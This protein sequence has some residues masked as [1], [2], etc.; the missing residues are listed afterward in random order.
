MPK[1]VGHVGLGHLSLVSAVCWSPWVLLSVAGATER[2]GR[3][4]HLRAFLLAGILTGVVFLADPR[5]VPPLFIAA[6]GYGAW[7][8]SLRADRPERPA[9]AFLTGLA[10]AGLAL[11]AVGAALALPL[12]EF[13][14]LSTRAELTA[15]SADTLAL[16]AARLLGLLI[17][18]PGT[19]AEWL[20]SMGSVA[21]VLAAAGC[22]GT[23]R[24]VLYWAALAVAALLLALGQATPL[25]KLVSMVPGF[26]MT[27]VPARWLFLA[28]MGLA[29]LAAYGLAA[30]EG[31]IEAAAARRIR[32]AALFAAA[33]VVGISL[34]VSL[35]SDVNVWGS[36]L[37]AVLSAA[38]IWL[39]S[40]G[41]VASWAGVALAGL[42]VAEL[43][44]IDVT[45]VEARPEEEALSPGQT[46]AS[47]LAER[48][49][50]R[51]FSPSYAV[52]QEAAAAAGLELADGVHPLQLSSYVAYMSEAAG[53]DAGDYSVTLPPFP[54][55]DPSDDWGP[56]L[57][58]EAL[59]L[60]GIGRIASTYPVEAPGLV[61][62]GAVGGV[63]LYRNEA[64][65][66][67][68]WVEPAGGS[69][70][71]R[72]VGSLSRTANRV[73]IAAEGPGRLVLSDPMY[74]GWTATVDETGTRIEVYRGVT[75]SISLA[76]GAHTIVFTFVP[77]SLLVGM[78]IAVVAAAVSVV[79]WR[80]P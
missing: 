32:L 46:V 77:V 41:R 80:R 79:L 3:P 26:D 11:I 29:A 59:G 17:A 27:R 13:V 65:R 19:S 5:W 24:R 70:S 6:A 33:L 78:A 74:P 22:A 48:G 21:L 12:A 30:M 28:G 35:S 52:P 49:E 58:P 25:G 67:M 2:V 1:L 68:A 9:R 61:S 14:G 7:R 20:A 71:V 50:S 45:L 39:R 43:F 40:R 54:T 44:S 23:A 63:L 51:V 57:N 73:E 38:V 55:G 18:L 75:R 69:G 60:L 42:L 72:N 53:F 10:A 4:R 31:A 37:F 62:D 47:Y 36:A 8:W 34:G 56:E 15:A 64:A 76:S 16:P 66:P